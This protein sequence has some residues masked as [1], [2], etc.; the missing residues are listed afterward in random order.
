[1]TALKGR[2]NDAVL[3]ACDRLAKKLH[4]QFFEPDTF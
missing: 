4:R 3:A 1:M 2:Q